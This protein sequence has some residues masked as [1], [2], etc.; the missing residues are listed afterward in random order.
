MISAFAFTEEL[1]RIPS[2]KPSFGGELYQ[3]K[4]HS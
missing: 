4:K 1:C 3:K 2:A